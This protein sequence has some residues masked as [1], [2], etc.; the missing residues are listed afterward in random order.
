MNDPNQRA[1]RF[2]EQ[3]A[4]DL[5]RGEVVFPTFIDATVKVRL[6]LN[7]PKTDV[8]RLA[9]IVSAE[10]LLSLK[11][12]RLANSAAVNPGG[13][14]VNDV[15]TAVLRVGFTAVRTTAVAVAMEQLLASKELESSFE[16]AKQ[17][18]EHC[19]DVAAR[20][21]VIAR[22]MTR[23]NPDEALFT[24]MIHDVGHFYL[25]SRAN[26]YPEL[27]QNAEEFEYVL[28][29]WHGEIGHAVLNAMGLADDLADAVGHHDQTAFNVPPKDVAGVLLLANVATR[30]PNPLEPATAEQ[31][32]W[33]ASGELGLI[34]LM[35]SAEAEIQSLISAL[36]G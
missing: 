23:I 24:G 4:A 21:Y 30:C 36:K 8:D 32:E 19:V 29:E 34:E 6:A 11:L 5:S 26:K 14:R 10:P 17:V 1:F 12:V 33:L 25:L 7:N 16:T 13:K 20:A 35:A 9:Q 2:L 15:K 18:W 3:L 28:R 31:T 27:T 22:A